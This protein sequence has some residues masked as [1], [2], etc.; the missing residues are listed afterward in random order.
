MQDIYRNASCA[1]TGTFVA[2]IAT[3]PICTIKTNYQN[4]ESKSIANTAQTMYRKFGLKVFYQASFPAVGAQILSTTSK[5]T[6]YKYLNNKSENKWSNKFINGITSGVI[7]SLATHPLD[8]VR[9]HMQMNTKI[10]PEI[11][12]IGPTI[13]YRGYSKTFSKIAVA[14]AL[15]FPLYDI[16]QSYTGNVVVASFFTGVVA[17]TIT[18]P[19]DYMKTRQMNGLNIW[20]GVNPFN[21]YKGLSLNLARIVPHFMI[22]MSVIEMCS[23]YLSK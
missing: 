15:Y 1:I 17:C 12:K 9:T 21:Y 6:L 10:V 19:L 14:S 4:T 7:T 16:F 13:F 11:K 2:E 18:H 22:T 23:N 5:Y 8:V 3:L 20:R